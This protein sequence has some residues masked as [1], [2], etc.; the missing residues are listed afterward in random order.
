MQERAEKNYDIFAMENLGYDPLPGIPYNRTVGEGIIIQNFCR[1][2]VANIDK[3]SGTAHLLIAGVNGFN[4]KNVTRMEA[5]TVNMEDT[6]KFDFGNYY[7]SVK[8][9]PE[10]REIQ[11][12][13]L[14]PGGIKTVTDETLFSQYTRPVLREV[15]S[16]KT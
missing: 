10:R 15:L 5:H 11:I 6:Y 3:S 9:D 8:P 14:C 7:L 2:V 1:I 16:E 4:L 13:F 12:S